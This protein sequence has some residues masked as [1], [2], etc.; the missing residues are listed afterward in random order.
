MSLTMRR[1]GTG[2][3]LVAVG[4]V[5]ALAGFDSSVEAGKKPAT[6]PT[7]S[8]DLKDFDGVDLYYGII[9][10]IVR[11]EAFSVKLFADEDIFDLVKVGKDAS[12]LKI[13]LD[14]N[15]NLPKTIFMVCGQR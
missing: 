9:A 14:T 11:S 10:T 13:A 4:L 2:T 5:I 12:T 8:F 7:K 1:T 6:K 15:K 3:L